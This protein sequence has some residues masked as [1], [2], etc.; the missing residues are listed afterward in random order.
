MKKKEIEKKYKELINN[1]D[2]ADIYDG[3]GTYDM[4][5]CEKCRKGIVTTYIDY[6]VTPFCIE[7]P[8]CGKSMFHEYT[9]KEKPSGVNIKEWVRPSLECA[10]KMTDGQLDHLFKGGLFLKEE[11]VNF[12]KTK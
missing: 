6:G 9:L 3:R 5:I 1:I 10:L 8:D 2:N 7:C 4:Y 11:L 12:T